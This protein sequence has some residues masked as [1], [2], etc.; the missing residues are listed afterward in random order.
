MPGEIWKPI[1]EWKEYFLV[2]NMG[3]IKTIPRTVVHKN[4]SVHYVKER[5]RKQIPGGAKLKY[6]NIGVIK[7]G[8]EYRIR[9]HRAVAV[10][11]IPNP[12]SKPCVDHI[13]T[14]TFDNRVTNLRWV[15]TEENANN[16]LTKKHIGIVKSGQRCYFYGKKRLHS[17]PILCIHPDG[18]EETFL[19]L[20]D[21]SLAGHC[22]RSIHYCLKGTYSHH[23]GC[24]WR[25]LN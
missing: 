25:Y 22:A 6:L 12:D 24:K 21:A 17:K 13:N 5:I 18:T 15:T 9:T 8:R 7:D 19:S 14:N 10:A 4:G 3:R 23:H 2:S 20:Y 16:E 1:K 11:F